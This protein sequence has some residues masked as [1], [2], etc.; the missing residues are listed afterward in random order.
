MRGRHRR[1]ERAALAGHIVAERMARGAQAICLLGGL[2]GALWH[3][4]ASILLGVAGAALFHLARP[5]PA[6]RFDKMTGRG[7]DE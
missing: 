7:R 2:V 6:E 3:G 5:G 4:F 1:E